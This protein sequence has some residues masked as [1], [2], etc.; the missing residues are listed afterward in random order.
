MKFDLLD[1]PPSPWEYEQDKV[2]EWFKTV[3]E[4]ASTLDLQHMWQEE[5]S[6]S[7]LP[8]VH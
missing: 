6:G 2:A 4:A 1:L 3:V 8:W 7:S 5:V